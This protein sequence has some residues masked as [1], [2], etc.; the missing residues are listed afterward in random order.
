M[1]INN[2][3]KVN[4]LL[5]ERI[6]GLEERISDLENDHISLLLKFCVCNN[7]GGDNS[8]CE[9]MMHY[10]ICDLLGTRTY[11]C[12][13]KTF[14][15]NGHKCICK[16]NIN[17]NWCRAHINGKLYDVPLTDDNVKQCEKKI[18]KGSEIINKYNPKTY[19]RHF[20]SRIK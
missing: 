6:N 3:I 7:D 20:L 12:R 5:I 14:E 13:S 19:I 16:N 8:S 18:L 15:V 2:L 17:V 11:N 9:S 4:R 1:D 10:C